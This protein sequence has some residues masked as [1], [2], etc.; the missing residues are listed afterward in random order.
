M[1]SPELS[2]ETPILEAAPVPTKVESTSTTP[3]PLRTI[4]LSPMVTVFSLLWIATLSQSLKSNPT[5]F[6]A[7]RPALRLIV[8]FSTT[9]PAYPPVEVP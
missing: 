3:Q 1:S 6:G 4:A 8:L 5:A 7:T 2:E 9:G